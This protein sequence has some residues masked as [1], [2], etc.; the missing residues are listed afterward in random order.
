MKNYILKKRSMSKILFLFLLTNLFALASM[1]QVKISG[2]VTNSKGI[3]IALASVSIGNN[4]SVST[5]INGNYEIVTALNNGKYTVIVS[6]VGYK[7][8]EET[9]TVNGSSDIVLNSTLQIDA[10][11]LDE[12]VVTGNVNK[13]SKK[14]LGNA[15]STINAAQLQNTG[16]T[17]LSAML[18]GRVMGAQ[19]T[20]NSGDAA[21][22]ISVKLRGVGSV[23]GSSEPLYIM[24]GVIIDNSSANV[25]NLNADTQGSR[26]QAGT[27]RLSDINPNDIE[28]IEVINGA[29]AAAIYG[30]RASNGVVQI[31]T[32]KGKNGKAKVSF[33]SSVQQSSLR[34]RWEMNDVPLR[35]GVATA[36]ALR[37][38]TVQDRLSTI[39]NFANVPGGTGPA[40]AG[41]RLLES[42][43]AVTRYDYQDDIFQKAIGTDNHL[44]VTGGTDKINYYFSS[45]YTKN[46]GIV[47]N[48]NFQ[49]YGFKART[50]VT[51]NNWAKLSG[52]LTYT[53]SRSKDKPNGNNFFSPVS[54]MTII[55]NVWNINERDANGKLLNV[56]FARVNPLSIIETFDI[57]QETNRS[58]ADAKLSLTPIKGLNIDITNG[59]DTY[60]QQGTTFQERMPY[61]GVNSVA[62]AF[63]PDGYVSNAKLNYFQWTGDVVASYKFNPSAKLQSTTTAGY[64][65]QYIKTSFTGQEGRDL[66]PTVRTISAA[67][68]F[69]TNPQESRTEQSIYGYFVQQTLGYN[70]KLFVTIAG[71]FDGSSAFSKDARNIFYPKASMSYNLSDESFWKNNKLN[72]WFNTFK[73]RASY[74]KAGNLTGVGPYDRFTNYSPIVYTSGGFAPSSRIGNPNIR[75]EIKEEIEFGADMQ[76]LQGRLGLQITKYNQKITDVLIPFNLPPSSGAGSILDNVGK[77]TNNGLEFMLTGTPVTTKDFKW[78]ASFLYSSNKNKVTEVY[79]NATFIGFD[80]SN[81]QGI[82]V[83]QPVGVY[84][85]NYYAKNADGSLLLKDVNGFKLPQIEK[86]NLLTGEAQRDLAGQPTGG[87]LRKV[88]GDPNPDFNISFNQEFT[89]KNWNFRMQVDGVYGFEVY[90]WDWITRNNVGNG[91]MAKQELL[92]QLPRGW[93]ASIGG[94]IGPRI[95]EEHVEDGSF[96]K[97]REISLGYTFKKLK[98]ADNIKVAVSG[99]NLFSKDS[100]RGFDPEVNSAGQS[101]VRG[102]DFGSVPIPKTIQ[103]SIIANF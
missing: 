68:N 14:Q 92:G 20:Q 62:A 42:K 12:V 40:A 49:R 79:R 90:N 13:T 1:A 65:A 98:F 47:R 86:G 78:N 55:D 61:A 101:Y 74:G 69:F 88:L 75:P 60:G 8:N 5:N 16:T 73:V 83:G 30:S 23:F 57:R 99:R 18:S 100:Y 97:L 89:Y 10:L 27:N 15:I 52:G 9:I 11:G 44:S 85:V 102:T 50:D 63:Y 34:N 96:T 77:M 84:Y 6:N 70:N 71:R 59:F 26:I 28:R 25:I 35:F 76:F 72:N 33:T 82:L 4:I 41:G 54:T 87:N 2:R 39:G 95:Q 81:T 17:N 24:D 22:G 21:G 103:F 51:L 29:A 3:G 94:F 45:S 36:P 56:E 48:T 37:L 19:V 46:E 66:L 53:N 31:F 58:V 7:N 43:Y 80:G 91:P 67:Q 64:S 32:K 38:S 93:V